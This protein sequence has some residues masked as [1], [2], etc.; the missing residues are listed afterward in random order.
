MRESDIRPEDLVDRYLELSKLDVKE[1]FGS[2]KTRIFRRCPACNHD[3]TVKGFEKNNF[4][5]V[6]CTKCYSLYVN[7]C[8]EPNQLEKFY[9]DSPSQDYCANTFFPAV[10]ESRTV[11][12]FKPRAEALKEMLLHYGIKGGGRVIDVGA[13]DG[14]MLNEL[15]NV[16]IGDEFIAV[17]PTSDLAESCK[18]K[19]FSVFNCF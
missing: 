18:S 19:G 3:D 7:P 4:D 2:Q 6:Y 14:T 9:S 16:G 13:G 15:K 17:E 12:V 1:F 11:R 10:S 5:F 8:P